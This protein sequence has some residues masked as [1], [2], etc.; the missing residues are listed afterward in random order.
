[1][2]SVVPPILVDCIETSSSICVLAWTCAFAYRPKGRR[3]LLGKSTSPMLPTVT[4]AMV[5]RQVNWNGKKGPFGQ[6]K[7]C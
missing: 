3:K 4:R 2:R 7:K 1:M 5:I 6:V